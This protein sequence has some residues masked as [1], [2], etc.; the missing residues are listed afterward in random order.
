MDG[1]GL[2]A[3]D[4]LAGAVA[5]LDAAMV[6]YDDGDPHHRISGVI[7]VQNTNGSFAQQLPARPS[8]RLTVRLQY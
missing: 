5:V 2:D 6:H 4:A 7:Q 3:F 1:L 8:E